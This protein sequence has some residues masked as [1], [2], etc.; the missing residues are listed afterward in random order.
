[1]S[2]YV[3]FTDT[4]CDVELE[5]LK[6]WGVECVSLTFRFEGSP[7]EYVCG[8]YPEKQFYDMMRAGKVARTAAV[9][10]ETFKER[11]KRVLDAGKDVLYLGFSG[12]L[13]NTAP[14]GILA[15]NELKEAYPERKISA[16]DTLCACGGLAYLIYHA[17]LMQKEGKSMEEVAAY[18]EAQAPC[19]AHWFTVADLVYLKRGGRITAATAL[20]GTMLH[21]KPV[22]HVDDE[23]KL[24]QM[25]KAKGRKQSMQM[26]VERYRE[27]AL[28]IHGPYVLSHTDCMEDILKLEQMLEEVSGHKAEL[29]TPVSPVIGSHVG[30]GLMFVSFPAKE[31]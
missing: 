22:L 28:D 19:I 29:I 12:G 15:A 31:R 21:I 20:A 6:E 27:T 2:E 23:G 13:S 4:G 7:E 18:V 11:F 3:I 9:N 26:L 5:R 14:A 10:I 30:P 25:Y 8:E 16:I 1:M 17:S 24:A